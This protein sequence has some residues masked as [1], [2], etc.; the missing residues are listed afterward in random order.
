[1]DNNRALQF[2]NLSRFIANFLCGWLL[3]K[4]GM[5]IREVALY[6]T[7][8]FLGNLFT[9]FWHGGG[10]KA[11]LNYFPKLSP[12]QGR[13]L[14]FNVFLLFCLLAGGSALAMWF[15][16]SL[17][18]EFFQQFRD[19]PHVF[20]LCLYI[21]WNT[22]AFLTHLFF[23]LKNESLAIIR[24]ASWSFSLQVLVVGIPA[25]WGA[26]LTI[27]FAGLSFLAL[28][29]FLY[30]LAVL[31]KRSHFEVDPT[32]LK[33]WFWIALPLTLHILAGNSMEYIDGWIVSR[34]FSGDGDFAI[35]RYGA[36][37]L[38][39][40]SLVVGALV[41]SSI[42]LLS[43]DLKEGA[44]H[45]KGQ[46]QKLAR[47]MYPLSIALLFLSPLLYPWVY[48]PEFRA[49]AWI[50]NIYLL[51]IA[52]RLLLPQVVLIGGD[53]R[54]ALV[55]SAI[56]ETVLNVA[57][58]LWWAKTLG[59]WGIAAA[60]VMAN[61]FNKGNLIVYCW[62]KLGIPPGAYIPWKRLLVYNLFLGLSF[63]LSFLIFGA[64]F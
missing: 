51:I 48:S 10:Q 18:A 37:E 22:P 33:A 60:T 7:L 2:F 36:R 23:L 21:A 8:L 64:S 58:S 5:P 30:A 45:L 57:L 63:Y 32:L 17:F 41:T 53:E 52:F 39:L 16:R 4:A 62:L 35:F 15:G 25:F 56:L 11:L 6:E 20:W 44:A 27:L 28:L 38:P 24:Y 3:V 13:K 46:T 61:A 40:V 29:R 34:F 9:F 14:L 47:W 42:P 50:F 43:G 54:Y 12:E 1:M 59:L 49:S 19:G 26:D 31:R 55:V